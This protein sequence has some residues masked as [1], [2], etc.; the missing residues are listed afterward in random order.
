M[1]TSPSDRTQTFPANGRPHFVNLRPGMVK[2]DVDFGNQP[3]PPG[4]IRGVKFNDT[5]GNGTQDPGEE[6]VP[7]VQICLW[8]SWR[9]TFTNISGNYRFTGVPAG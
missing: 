9:C 7:D 8:P 1:S 4:E 5:S 2:K 3:V 6:G